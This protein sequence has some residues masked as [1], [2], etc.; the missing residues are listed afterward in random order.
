MIRE[1]EVYKI[2][3][4]SRVHG[5]RGEVNFQFTDD[6]W[7]RADADYLILRVDGILVPFFLEEYRFRND[8]VALVHFQDIHSAN[9]AQELVG[10]EVYFPHALT[11]EVDDEQEYSWKYFTGFRVVD[12]EAGELGEVT[13]VDDSTPNVLFYVGELM[14]PAVEA[15]IEEIDHKERT[16]RMHLPEGLLD[17]N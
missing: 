7:D 10:L 4:I 1:E 11:P 16:L 15:F 6:V 9:D 14:I 13:M 17:M 3:Y 8:S 5:T 12:A 2:G